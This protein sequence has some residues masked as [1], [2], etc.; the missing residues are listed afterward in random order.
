[1]ISDGV[2]GA[3]LAAAISGERTREPATHPAIA[4]PETASSAAATPACRRTD[5]R[6]GMQR[7]VA[8]LRL[9]RAAVVVESPDHRQ[10]GDP[11]GRALAMRATVVAAALAVPVGVAGASGGD[12]TTPSETVPSAPPTA[13]PED[14]TGDGADATD[15]GAGSLR[16]ADAEYAVDILLGL[17]PQEE[18]EAFWNAEEEQR[19]L[20]IQACMNEA[21]FEY[22]PEVQAAFFDPMAGLTPLEYAEQWGFGMWTMMDPESPMNAGADDEWPNEDVVNALSQSEQDAWYELNNR[23]W[24]DAYTDDDD[25]YRNPMVQQALE[26]FYTDVEN[27]PR[28]QAALD[29]WRDCMEEAGYP[30]A[31][32]QAM[33]DAIYGGEENEEIWELQSQF[34]ESEAWK[35]ESA[36][37]DQW[38]QLVDEEIGTAVANATC[39][40]PVQEAREEVTAELRPGLVDV[41][42]TID[43]SLPPVTFE[44]EGA[45][46]MIVFSEE[47]APES[48]PDETGSSEPAGA[49]E[50][51]DLSATPT[52]TP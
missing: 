7:I 26:D 39:S 9:R 30:Y 23:C 44:G 12:S 34:F 20:A 1:V 13:S 27:D 4:T 45:D 10:G 8:E 37:H 22:N 50:A 24:N 46:G 40:T 32:E 51:I 41:W 6:L 18:M 49:P 3:A 31:S 33:Y 47:G 42:Q 48:L 25:V 11:M 29:G 16:T 19:Q 43:W 52:S 5:D 38:Q 15:G 2:G 21:G 14:T 28:V 36:D 35:P 17:V